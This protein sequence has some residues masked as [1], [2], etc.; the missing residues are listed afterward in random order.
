MS[1]FAAGLGPMFNDPNFSVAATWRA[2]GE[3]SGSAVRVIFREADRFAS[4]GEGRFI[5]DSSFLDVRVSE[6]A[7]LRSG[8]TFELADGSIFQVRGDPIRDVER[9]TWSCEVREL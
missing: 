1:A 6:V 7:L 3:G 8:D 5:T 2:G 4:F 9:V